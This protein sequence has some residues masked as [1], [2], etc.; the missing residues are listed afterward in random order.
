MITEKQTQ[1]NNHDDLGMEVHR[2]ETCL[3]SHGRDEGLEGHTLQSR[4]GGRK[5]RRA[6]R[7]AYKPYYALSEDERILREEREKMRVAKLM[8]RMKAKGR[9]IAPYNTTQFIMA[10]HEVEN[11]DLVQLLDKPIVQNTRKVSASDEDEEYYLSPS[12]DDDF[13]SKEF[14]KDYDKQHVN[15][16]EMMSKKML[17]KEYIVILRK[18]EALELRLGV[19]HERE[20][21][22]IREQKYRDCLQQMEEELESLRKQNQTLQRHNSEI[23]ELLEQKSE[24][25][26]KEGGTIKEDQD[27]PLNDTGY[28]SNQY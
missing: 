17:M 18:N 20:N 3:E 15:N 7:K 4:Q 23:H 28:E 5:V 24:F 9:V 8:E 26:S 25:Y 21:K 6:K 2:T 16:L 22:K 14:M 1:E 12:D 10:D 27:S 11:V 19:I 13:I